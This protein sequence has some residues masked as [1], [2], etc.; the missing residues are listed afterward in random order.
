MLLDIDGTLVAGSVDG[1][2]TAGVRAM[3]RATMEIT[4]NNTTFGG[5]HYA[6]RTDPQIAKMLLEESGSIEPTRGNAEHLIAKYLRFLA[7]EIET[8]PYR[9]LGSPREA[10]QGLR[11]AGATVALGTGNV[12]SGAFIKLKSA[13]IDDLFNPLQGGYGEDGETRAALLRSG[14]SN[15]DPS[16][17]LPVIVVGDTPRDVA[18]AREIGARCIGIP[19]GP[20]SRAVL[21]DAGADAVSDAVNPGLVS[22]TRALV[23]ENGR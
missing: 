23:E 5:A 3:K 2:S 4:G 11:A 9:V 13:G 14:A 17:R 12:R 20:N 18:A 15:C 16:G 1:P 7:E 22:L 21:R 8:T 6:G 10:V 19:Y